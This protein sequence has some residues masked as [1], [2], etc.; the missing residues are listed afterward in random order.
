MDA[1]AGGVIDAA[2]DRSSCEFGT[3]GRRRCVGGHGEDGPRKLA[4]PRASGPA[5]APSSSPRRLARLTG[6]STSEGRTDPA[7]RCGHRARSRSARAAALV[8]LLPLF[9]G[10]CF[11][12]P[13]S[14]Y[15]P[16]GHGYDVAAGTV[17]LYS[18]LSERLPEHTARLAVWIE[19]DV[20]AVEQRL[21]TSL[22]APVDVVVSDDFQI[23]PGQFTHQLGRHVDGF[24]NHERNIVFVEFRADLGAL[25]ATLRHE[26]AH[27]AIARHFSELPQWLSEGV[28]TS[29]EDADD[30]PLQWARL[31]KFAAR[32][33]DRGPVELEELIG[34]EV[35]SYSDYN[36]VWAAFYVLERWL[37]VPPMD[38]LHAWQ[39]GAVDLAAASEQFDAFQRSLRG[40][41]GFRLEDVLTAVRPLSELDGEDAADILSVLGQARAQPVLALADAGTVLFLHRKALYDPLVRLDAR[42]TRRILRQAVQPFLDP[43]V[44]S[45]LGPVPDLDDQGSVHAAMFRLAEAQAAY[46]EIVGRLVPGC[47]DLDVDLR[48][49]TLRAHHDG[50]ATWALRHPDVVER[51]KAR[52]GDALRVP[53]LSGDRIDGELR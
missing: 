33:R 29:C 47:D 41:D 43:I 11:G 44:D 12:G 6:M 19:S 40:R 52:D 48:P 46:D 13:L 23:E 9:A 15:V 45:R 30:A 53:R 24:Y 49:L 22:P 32:L 18:T 8:A 38:V 14:G 35:E 2:G 34:R 1:V 20:A 5:G 27:A 21:G 4:G 50:L 31:L 36:D 10:G 17:R 37:A 7:R 3:V 16:P 25:R 42:W 26:L 39:E 51:W 28:A